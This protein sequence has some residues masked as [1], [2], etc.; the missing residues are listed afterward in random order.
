MRASAAF[1]VTELGDQAA[2]QVNLG[3]TTG[4][5]G[6]A[7]TETRN[8]D[9]SSCVD[10]HRCIQEFAIR[11]IDFIRNLQVGRKSKPATGEGKCQ[12]PIVRRSR[13]HRGEWTGWRDIEDHRSF[14]SRILGD[15]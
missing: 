5:A 14:R 10:G 1:L 13:Q 3:T 4:G 9:I 12:C 7:A 6:D 15:V 11:E 2:G 8:P